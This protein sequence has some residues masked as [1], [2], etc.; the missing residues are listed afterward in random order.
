[1]G[2][3]AGFIELAHRFFVDEPELVKATDD[4]VSRR[5]SFALGSNP[6]AHQLDPP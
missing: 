2:F 1:M 5:E 3:Q 6:L 4:C